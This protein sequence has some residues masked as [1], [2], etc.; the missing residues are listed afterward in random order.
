[1]GVENFL[2]A[3]KEMGCRM[4]LKIHF[5]HSYLDFFLANLGAISDEQ[6]EKFHQHIQAM[7]ARYQGFWDKGMLAENCWMLYRDVPTH[8]Y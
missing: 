7:E 5:L 6:G 2:E 1:M 3:Y 8:S 4:S